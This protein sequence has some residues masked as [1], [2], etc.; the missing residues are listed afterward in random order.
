MESSNTPQQEEK[1]KKRGGIIPWILLILSLGGN[2]YLF[3]MF[4]KEKKRANEQVEIVKTVYVERDNVQNELL[5][6]KD[7]YA[8]LQTTDAN[9]Q[10]E[11]EAQKA[12]IEELI[13]EAEKHKGDAYYI[14][15]LKKETDTLREIMKGYVHTIDSLNTLNQKLIV[16]KKEITGQL[17]KEKDKTT[18]LNRDKEELQSTITKGSMLTSNSITAMGV[19]LKSGG[20][21]QVPTNKAKRADLIKV[22]FNL[23][24]NKI[25]K[26]GPKDVYVRIITP[27]GKEMAKGYDDNYRFIFNNS[28]GYYAGKTN[29]NYANAE[30]GV[31]AVCEG[32]S[33]LLP[34]KYMIEITADGAVIG[35]TT[36]TLD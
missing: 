36:L 33:P 34:G 1:K 21:K 13:K 15:K 32:S 26:S 5:K 9:M 31:T 10:A 20:K 3:Y 2:G 28:A 29:I 12:R 35:Q 19:N 22:S 11:I 24:E 23:S 6:L 18:Q 30:I 17:N 14:A 27:D 25:A 16:E 8:A 4:D 7:E